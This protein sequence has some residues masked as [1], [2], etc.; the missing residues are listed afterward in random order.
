MPGVTPQQVRSRVLGK[1]QD[2][3]K[4]G[5]LAAALEKRAQVAKLESEVQI[6][7]EEA[8]RMKEAAL[9]SEVTVAMLARRETLST[10]LLG[11][12]IAAELERL[13]RGA[14]SSWRAAL[15]K[16]VEEELD[17]QLVK[18]HQDIEE[19]RA[20]SE[21]FQK[22][23]QEEATRAAVAEASLAFLM[24]REGSLRDNLARILASQ[25]QQ[26]QL[27]VFLAWRSCLEQTQDIDESASLVATLALLTR[28]DQAARGLLVR[29]MADQLEVLARGAFV[30]WAQAVQNAPVQNSEKTVQK[31]GH[32][33]LM[34]RAFFFWAEMLLD[35]REKLLRRAFGSFLA[36]L[37]GKKEETRAEAKAA[38]EDALARAREADAIAQ[39][40]MGVVT[41]YARREQATRMAYATLLAS[42]LELLVC[43][44]FQAWRSA[45]SNDSAIHHGPESQHTNGVPAESKTTSPSTASRIKNV[46]DVCNRLS[47]LE[48]G[49]DKVSQHAATLSE[50]AAHVVHSSPRAAQPATEPVT[51]DALE[52][53]APAEPQTANA[54]EADAQSCA[55]CKSVYLPDAIFCRNCGH[56]RQAPG[57]IPVAPQSSGSPPSS[58]RSLEHGLETAPEIDT[59]SNSSFQPEF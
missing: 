25:L 55:N 35:A 13:V 33:T 52:R 37:H 43:G 42:Q 31:T 16:E 57:D 50:T 44:A 4:S 10:R 30:S 28:Q 40:A 46:D 59:D 18:C 41:L 3:A 17:S 15:C 9:Q 8:A 1:L 34:W 51:R 53:R 26:F 38:E 56:K 6:A 21:G 14:F 45:A 11:T 23:A 48:A 29:R 22:Q 20:S 58:S 12:V 2:A 32:A 47:G 7:M 27:G 54:S 36:A 49:L 39:E 5:T 24:R 19:M